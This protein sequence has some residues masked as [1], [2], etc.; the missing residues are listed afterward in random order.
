MFRLELGDSSI[1]KLDIMDI[2]RFI[3]LRKDFMLCGNTIPILLAL[4][5]A[6]IVLPQ[7]TRFI[8]NF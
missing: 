5:L 8:N 6:P 2:E 4:S 7:Y 3:E 1:F